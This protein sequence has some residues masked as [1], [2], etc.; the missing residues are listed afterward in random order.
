MQM[1]KKKN[2]KPTKQPNQI[3]IMLMNQRGSKVGQDLW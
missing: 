2:N 3:Q 1:K